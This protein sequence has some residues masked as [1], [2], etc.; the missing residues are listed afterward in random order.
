MFPADIRTVHVP[1]FE[2]DTFRRH[3]G[4]RLTEAVVKEI[5]A[6]TPYKVVDA[7]SADSVLTG[8]I[9]SMNK[10]VLAEEINDNPRDLETAFQVV[11][12][13]T[14]RRGDPLT[15]ETVAPISLFDIQ[16][17]EAA[18]F[19]PEGGQSIATSQQSAIQRVARQIVS[20]MN[21]PW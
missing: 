11:V 5:E 6:T 12:Q 7:A 17:T 13:W 4:E 1:M 21:A 20:Q 9:I 2:N 18:H 3:L 8:R 15:P 10:R 19:V 16:L 14:D